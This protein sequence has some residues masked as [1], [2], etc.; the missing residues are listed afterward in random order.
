MKSLVLSPPL[1]RTGGIQRY[2]LTLVRALRELVGERGVRLVSLQ[3]RVQPTVAMPTRRASSVSL[4]Q[5]LSFGLRAIREVVRWKP[6][7]IIC[8]H[9]A[10]GPVGWLAATL[11]RGPYWIVAH[12]IEAWSALPYAKRAA[13][14]HAHR[15]LAI[16]TFS[17]E[18]VVKRHGI[19]RERVA[20]LPC[21]FDERPFSGD[22]RIQTERQ[23]GIAANI[24]RDRRVVLTV[25]RM[26]A[27]ERY[28][29][30]DVVMRALPSVVARVPNLTYAVVGDGDDRARLERM[31][32]E[33]GLKEHVLFTGELSDD[34]L[35]GMYRRSEVFV[36]PSRTVIKDRSPKG[37]GFGIAFMEAMAFGRPVIGPSYG[38][39][40]ELIRHSENGLLVDPED[41]RELAQALLD[42]LGNPE[43]AREMGRAGR[44][45]V[46]KHRSHDAFRH[47]LGQILVA[48]PP[49]RIIGVSERPGE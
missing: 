7:L 44:E 27:S 14:R 20:S 46:M 24:P 1:G 36:L 5:K 8:T 33:L 11:G 28:K 35:A 17:R 23:S 45:W 19:D 47:R 15:V 38:A 31:A 16:S 48:C 21:A 40:V 12:G 18:E 26:A 13:L 6:D 34:Q 49:A 9:L 29:G 41:S 3:E 39:P 30:H 2:T 42:V 37:E 43:A 22:G 4:F 10:L 25:A 32:R